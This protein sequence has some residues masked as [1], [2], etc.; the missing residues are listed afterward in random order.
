MT[1]H[2]RRLR[3]QPSL[4]GEWEAR[5]KRGDRALVGWSVRTVP[6]S[7][8]TRDICITS[9]LFTPYEFLV[10]LLLMNSWDAQPLRVS[11]SDGYECKGRCVLVRV[12]RRREQR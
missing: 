10:C 6:L 1:R 5:K 4:N 3:E 7:I 2:K 9:S 12:K 8:S 11:S